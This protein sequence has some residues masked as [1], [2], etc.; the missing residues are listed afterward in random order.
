MFIFI[1][2]P[3]LL[4]ADG[5]KNNKVF[6]GKVSFYFI[7]FFVVLE[8]HFSERK[9]KRRSLGEGSREP[10]TPGTLLSSIVTSGRSIPTRQ[11]QCVSEHNSYPG[12]CALQ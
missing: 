1:Y 7:H 9:L 8:E 5:R 6:L 10:P 4:C 2:F 3:I 12:S 11:E